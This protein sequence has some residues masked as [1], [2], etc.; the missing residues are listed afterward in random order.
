MFWS[1]QIWSFRS[2]VETHTFWP[3]CPR[4]F[5][6]HK[7]HFEYGIVLWISGK[8]SS[9]SVNLVNSMFTKFWKRYLN[10]PQSTKNA[11]V[12]YLTDTMPL[13]ALL[14]ELCQQR[15]GSIYLPS[16]M[17]GIQLS[18]F[19]ELPSNEDMEQEF[20][21]SSIPSHFWRSR[22]IVKLPTNPKLRKKLCKYIINKSAV[23][24]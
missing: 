15:V 3:G 20:D 10:L 8:L 6:L 19:N 9:S 24:P 1:I 17:N 22:V 5:L 7:F 11:L 13:M 2:A 18:F 23:L 12:Y 16:C 21:W 14:N 4:D